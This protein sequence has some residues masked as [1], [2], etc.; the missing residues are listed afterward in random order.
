MTSETQDKLPRGKVL[1]EE[2]T[3]AGALLGG[4]IGALIG[5][6]FYVLPFIFGEG[7]SLFSPIIGIT[8]G[9]SVQLLGRGIEAKFGVIGVSFAALAHVVAGLVY[10]VRGLGALLILTSMAFAFML[11]F[12]RLSYAD[13]KAYTMD[14]LD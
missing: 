4:L 3:V 13:K 6:T 11:S 1:V 14:N 12:R 8:V 9:L 5:L 10:G 2:Q 7:T